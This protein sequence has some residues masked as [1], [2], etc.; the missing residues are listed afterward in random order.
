MAFAETALGIGALLGGRR[1]RRFC[2]LCWQ[3]EPKES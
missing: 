1:F 3:F 2:R